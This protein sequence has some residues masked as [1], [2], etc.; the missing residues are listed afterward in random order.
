MTMEYVRKAYGVPA[1]RGG[2]VVVSWRGQKR[3]ATI[4]SEK[5]GRLVI[6]IDGEKAKAIFH[7]TWGI[8][9]VEQGETK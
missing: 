8:E 5:N 7:P 1:R 2:R 6:K 4:K 9:Y 3:N